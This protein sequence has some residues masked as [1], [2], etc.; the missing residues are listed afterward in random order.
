MKNSKDITA[1]QTEFRV[2]IRIVR[3]SN[4]FES[5]RISAIRSAANCAPRIGT[6]NCHRISEFLT[7]FHLAENLWREDFRCLQALIGLKSS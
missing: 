6:F 7:Y 1:N 2:A 5:L 3:F 4:R